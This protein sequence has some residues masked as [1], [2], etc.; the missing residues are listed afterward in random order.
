MSEEQKSPL[1]TEENLDFKDAKDLTVGE[2]VRKDSE[3]KAGVTD[4]DG[5]L[6]KYIKQ[7]REE[8]ASQKFDTKTQELDT[9]ALDDFIK[10][11]REELENTGLIESEEKS[12]P[13]ANQPADLGETIVAPAIEPD[14]QTESAFEDVVL[15]PQETQSS[16]TEAEDST[17]PDSEF[18]RVD[19]SDFD[20]EL[21]E[22]EKR[23]FYKRKG[24]IL[25]LLATLVLAIGGLIFGLN[26]QN[27]QTTTTTT[28]TSSSS[29]TSAK[30]NSQSFKK[31]YAAFFTDSEKTKL[32]NS[33]F[34]NLPSL[35]KILNKLKNTSYY[36][37]AKKQYDSLKRQIA[38]INLVNG[39]FK[40][41]AIVDGEQKTATV[42]DDANFDDISDDDLNTGNATLD[43]LLKSVVADGRQQLADKAANASSS[44]AGSSASSD[45]AASSDSANASSGSSSSQASGSDTSA[46]SS[47]SANQGSSGSSAAIVGASGYGISSYN[48]ATLQ[49]DRSRVPYNDAMIADSNNS[50]W[51][52]NPG[53]LEKIIATSQARGYI[54]GNDYI[55]EKV[56]IINGNGYYNMFKPDGTYLFS[57]NC[58][59]GYFVGNASGNSDSLDY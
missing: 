50:A 48:P 40:T 30:A 53:V 13:A 49:R 8:V 57:I 10:K 56:N 21:D 35:E 24:V 44:G 15:E 20:G 28:T 34:A 31:S 11:Q 6:D 42:K 41:N 18:S 22:E 59:T 36:T 26:R 4:E 33:A 23:P 3:L 2:A 14:S 37:N 16:L 52:F 51:T 45:T 46:S 47:S 27:S 5:V 58:K 12:E 29:K 17:R 25:G 7:H 43:A 54:T 55:L 1:E 19:Y 9:K 38:A 32:K 39:K